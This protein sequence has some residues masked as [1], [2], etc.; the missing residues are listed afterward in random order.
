MKATMSSLRPLGA[1]SDSISVV[2]PYLYLSTSMSLTSS[3]VSI[4]GIFFTSSRLPPRLD[5]APGGNELFN[6][7]C[8]RRPAEA[9]AQAC[10]CELGRHLHRRQDMRLRH[11]AGGAGR[12]RGHGEAR[13]IERHQR[14]FSGKPRHGEAAGVRQTLSLGAEDHGAFKPRFKMVTQSLDFES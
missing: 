11:L 6:F 9:H 10:A 2:K 1:R 12:A 14:G 4:S 7:L 3:I 13:K 8:R 5:A